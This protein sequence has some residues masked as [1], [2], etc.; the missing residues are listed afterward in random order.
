[1]SVSVSHNYP[2]ANAMLARYDNGEPILNATVKIY[3]HTDFYNQGVTLP[4]AET[5]TDVDGKW[6]DAVSLE[7][8]RSWVV[9]IQKNVSYGPSTWEVTT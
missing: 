2:H 6:Q 4:V 9:V 7:D 8:G 3:N 1:M 5:T